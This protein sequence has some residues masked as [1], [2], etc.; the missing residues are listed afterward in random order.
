MNREEASL[1]FRLREPSIYE[2]ASNHTDVNKG[3]QNWGECSEIHVPGNSDPGPAATSLNYAEY[4]RRE[5]P[6]KRE[7]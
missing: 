5:L 4:Q 7:T 6:V 3:S 2:K 1:F